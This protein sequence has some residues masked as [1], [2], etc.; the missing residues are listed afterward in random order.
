[1]VLTPS[2]LLV[3]LFDVERVKGGIVAAERESAGQKLD[4]LPTGSPAHPHPSSS[5]LVWVESVQDG[6]E[7]QAV[8]P[9]R[10]EVGDADTTVAGGDLLAPLQ[11]GLAGADQSR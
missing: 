4:R 2:H 10:G 1:M 3:V 9:G 6:T 8:A 11:Q 5:H 7:G